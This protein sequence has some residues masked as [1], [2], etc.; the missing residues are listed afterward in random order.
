MSWPYYVGIARRL[1]SLL[2]DAELVEIPGAR[3]GAPVEQPDLCAD[4]L[5]LFAKRIELGG[6]DRIAKTGDR[7]SAN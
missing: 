6:E 1:V 2:P 7:D 4:R 5:R 3:H